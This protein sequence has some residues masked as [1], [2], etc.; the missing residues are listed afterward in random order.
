MKYPNTKLPRLCYS[1]FSMQKMLNIIKGLSK[2]KALGHNT[3]LQE[4]CSKLASVHLNRLLKLYNQNLKLKTIHII[5][6]V[7]I[8]CIIL[9]SRNCYILNF[10][11][12][13]CLQK[14][15]FGRYDS[16]SHLAG[17]TQNVLFSLVKTSLDSCQEESLLLMYDHSLIIF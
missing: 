16:D 15:R 9:R 12:A 11:L 17:R 13:L 8:L 4:L 7:N 2:A 5:H 3:L 1:R 14:H 6:S 10:S